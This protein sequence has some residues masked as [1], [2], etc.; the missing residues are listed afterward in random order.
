MIRDGLTSVAPLLQ[1]YE[2]PTDSS[3]AKP[4]QS[5]VTAL[6]SGFYIGF[7]GVF[8][9][10]SRIAIVYTSFSYMGKN[11]MRIEAIL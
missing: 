4:F 3:I 11:N 9:A 10:E 2:F 5:F 6:N 8:N 7:R 1:Q